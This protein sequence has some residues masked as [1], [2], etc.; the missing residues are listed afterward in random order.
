MVRKA[1]LLAVA[2]AITGCAT[3]G[4]FTEKMDGF[5]GQPEAVLVGTYGPP[6]SSYQLTDGSRVIQYTRGQTMVMPG[7]TTYEPVRTTTTGNIT[8]RQ[9]AQRATGTYGQTSTSYVP[10]QSPGTTLAFW[11]TV[12]FTISK[13]GVVQRWSAEG[14]NCVAS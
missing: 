8:M 4:R 1:A 2:T 9:G 6:Q 13:D 7:A 12:T 11:C 5:V 14:N 10:Q 3:S